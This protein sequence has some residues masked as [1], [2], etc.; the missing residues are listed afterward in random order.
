MP[1][2]KPYT[3]IGIR[4]LPCYRCGERPSVHQWNICADN[5]V[6]R[7]ICLECDIDLNRMVLEWIKDPDIDSKM[8][9]YI[10]SVTEGA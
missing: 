1:R 10:A 4:R 6:F 7:A 5:N 8:A 2:T 3:K 9:E